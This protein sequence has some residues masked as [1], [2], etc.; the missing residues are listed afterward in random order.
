MVRS[1]AVSARTKVI[2]ATKMVSNRRNQC[3]RYCYG[4]IK[5]LKYGKD[6][7]PRKA[8]VRYRNSNEDVFRE[9]YRAVRSLVVIHSVDE[10]DLL[11]ELGKMAINVDLARK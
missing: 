8:K 10:S 1:M 9:T 6:G 11:T 7:K 5:D 3:W 4:I 2:E